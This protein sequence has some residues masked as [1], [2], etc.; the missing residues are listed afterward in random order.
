[1]NNNLDLNQITD[2]SSCSCFVTISADEGS[3]GVILNCNQQTCLYFG[4]KQAEI[5]ST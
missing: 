1:M 2:F 4:Y 3:E 5:L